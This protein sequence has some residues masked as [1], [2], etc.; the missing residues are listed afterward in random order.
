MKTIFVTGG[1]GFIGSHTCLSLLQ[2]GYEVYVLDSFINSSK[3][4]LSK[5]KLI[6][7]LKSKDLEKNLHI[8]KGDIRKKEDLRE[9]FLNLKKLNKSFN[10]VIHFAGLK[11]VRDSVLNPIKYWEFNVK[12]AINLIQVMQEFNCRTIVFSSS[13]SVYGISNKF[14]LNE[15][16]PI[17]PVNPYAT[18]KSVVE[19]FLDNL[20]INSKECW[21]IANLRY[22]NPIGAHSSGLIGENPNHIPSNIFPLITKVAS[23]KLKELTVF[24]DNWPTEDGFAVRDYIHVMDLAEGHISALEY[25]SSNLPQIINLNV[26]TGNGISVMQLIERFQTINNVTVPYRISQRREGDVARLVADNSKIKKLLNWQP[27]R[28]IEEMCLDGWKWQQLNPDGYK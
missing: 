20:S 12:G 2:K 27:T 1:A 3:L 15:K 18:T 13:A 5:V 23:K 4:S 16:D 17:N 22:F 8:F 28:D 11:S 14:L 6:L 7:K 19:K 25:L 21:R 26:G 9:V 10:S 24:G